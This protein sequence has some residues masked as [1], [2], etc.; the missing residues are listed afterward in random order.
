MFK[1]FD[2]TLNLQIDADPR[3]ARSLRRLH[4]PIAT[5]LTAIEDADRLERMAER[6]FDAAD[7]DDLL[8]TP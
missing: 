2:A 3:S 1:P 7:W 8:A 5:I 4:K 6:I